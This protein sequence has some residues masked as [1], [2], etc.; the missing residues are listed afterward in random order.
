LVSARPWPLGSGSVLSS[1]RPRYT[2]VMEPNGDPP[3]PE[4]RLTGGSVT[5]VR[6]VGNT[7]R[8]GAGPW[9]PAVHA[10]LRHLEKVGFDG[11]PRV[12]GADEQGREIL[13]YVPGEVPESATPEVVTER[14]L[15]E[16]GRLLRRYHR[17]VS[18]FEL[19]TGLRWH[20]QTRAGERTIV[21]HNDIA[22][23]NT[24]FRGG[25]P[26]A[27]LD[28]DLASPGPPAW[29]LAHAAWQFVPLSDDPGCAGH[30]WPVPPDRA[31][32]LRV[33]CDGYGLPEG[34][35]CG[36]RRARGR[37]DGVHGPWHRAARCRGR[38]GSQA[39]RA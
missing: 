32:R 36:I 35:T 17:A 39:A 1:G 19:P 16:V 25:R 26:V 5:A 27:F 14:A 37:T 12:L 21:C 15:D 34:G 31:S 28:W 6:K 38:D 2:V 3:A 9:T 29:D 20:H 4:E 11:A 10:L 18:G 22:P 30:G 23:K 13:A 8:R 7:V 33:L 24:V